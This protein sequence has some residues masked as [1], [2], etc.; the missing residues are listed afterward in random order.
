[1]AEEPIETYYIDSRR[2]RQLE[3]IKR[4]L[5]SPDGLSG[6]MRRDLANLLDVIVQEV[7]DNPVRD[8]ATD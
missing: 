4:S 6:D 5:Y 3:T 2:L 7:T 8:P 1:M